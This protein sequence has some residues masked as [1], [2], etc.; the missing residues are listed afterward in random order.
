MALLAQHGYGKGSKII[1]GLSNG[2]ISGVIFSPKG[3]E[4]KKITD[5]AKKIQKEHKF[6]NIYFD[7]QFYLCAIQ[8]D[9]AYGKLPS[10]EYC[11]LSLNR[12]ILSDY[13]YLQNLCDSVYN[14]QHDLDVSAYI[15]PT[16]LFNDFEDKESQIA[17]SLSK[18]FYEKVEYPDSQLYVSLC[19]NDSAFKDERKMN[20]FLDTISLLDIYGFYLIIDRTNPNGKINEI[21]SN[22]LANI[23]KFIYNLSIINEYNIIVGYSDLLSLPL[24]AVSNADFS[25]GWFS[26]SK[27][28]SVSNYIK[29]SGG[30]RPKKRYTSGI[31]MNSILLLPE[32]KSLI[33]LDLINEVVSDSKYN[34]RLLPKFNEIQ[35]NDEV[36]CLH[37]WHVV[38]QLIKNIQ[39][40]KGID[41]RLLYLQHKLD[42]AE[43]IYKIIKKQTPLDYSSKDT[44]IGM[45][46]EAIN[47]FKESMVRL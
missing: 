46:K 21:N 19:I 42:K 13:F 36:S 33:D 35:W 22:I 26:N 10:Y 32:F 25:S 40:E 28:F 45:W 11:N 9:I 2:D 14:I 41:D 3:D 37:N 44:Y 34:D 1:K 39:S 43:K 12:S 30:R 23:M 38:S 29:S 15:S 31:L 4:L 47:I 27:R 24:A 20:S 7:P 6:A 18:L 5:Y 17:L 16:I 8:G